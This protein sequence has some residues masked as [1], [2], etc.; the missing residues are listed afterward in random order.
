MVSLN[1]PTPI[2]QGLCSFTKGFVSWF[3]AIPSAVTHATQPNLVTIASTSV[4]TSICLLHTHTYI[5]IIYMLLF[6][7]YIELFIYIYIYI[8]YV[9]IYVYIESIILYIY[10]YSHF[11]IETGETTGDTWPLF[12]CGVPKINN[13]RGDVEFGRSLLQFLHLSN[14]HPNIA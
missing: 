7:L 5:Y 9:Y 3:I 6:F 12:F 4:K 13:G 11:R 14:V 10:I 1:L 8:M 2:C